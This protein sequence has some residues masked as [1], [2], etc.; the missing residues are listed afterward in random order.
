MNV[1]VMLNSTC[2]Y[3]NITAKKFGNK[4]CSYLLSKMNNYEIILE[5]D[6][7]YNK[8]GYTVKYIVTCN[9]II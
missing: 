4:L 2:T 8:E 9:K 5:R 6:R 3:K 1:H 7:L